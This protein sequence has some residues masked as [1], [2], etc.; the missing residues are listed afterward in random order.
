MLVKT[1]NATQRARGKSIFILLQQHYVLAD[2]ISMLALRNILS[3]PFTALRLV[4]FS[5]NSLR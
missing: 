5:L 3:S 4:E 2:A 1:Q